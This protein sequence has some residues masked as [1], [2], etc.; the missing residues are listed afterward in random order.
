M[1][2]SRV[3]LRYTGRPIARRNSARHSD[4]GREQGIARDPEQFECVTL[5]EDDVRRTIPDRPSI[6]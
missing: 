4:N 2:R 5:R 6:G 3:F 1:R